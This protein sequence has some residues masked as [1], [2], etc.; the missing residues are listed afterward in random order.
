MVLLDSCRGNDLSYKFRTIISQA[1]KLE[2]K[3]HYA[4]ALEK[5]NRAINIDSTKSFA[6]VMRG[7]LK[8]I[9]GDDTS[10]IEDFSKAIKFN[11]QNTAAYFY[12]AIS[13]SSI[14][15]EDSAIANFNQAITTKKLGDFSFD[16]KNVEYLDFEEQND[17]AMH[18][19]RYFR[20]VSFYSKKYYSQSL[21]DFK[22]SLKHEY[23][24]A[25]SLF[26][27]GLI[28]FAEGKRSEGCY[29]LM[30]ARKHG[31]HEADNYLNNYCK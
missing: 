18:V 26:S 11:P 13:F 6:F 14:E 24:V 9:L 15:N 25:E 3:G 21:E 4:K 16:R 10:A 20:G 22:Y 31:K 7:K 17:V 19:I 28:L 30:E 27:I 2:E 12:K 23:N 29:Y 5:V 1:I 8:G